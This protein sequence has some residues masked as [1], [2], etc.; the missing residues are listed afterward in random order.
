MNVIRACQCDLSSCLQL[1]FSGERRVRLR[2]D[3]LLPVPIFGCVQRSALSM[4]NEISYTEM[5]CQI[6]VKQSSGCEGDSS[7]DE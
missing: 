5:F 6:A 1:V 4:F 2:G 7:R 3:I